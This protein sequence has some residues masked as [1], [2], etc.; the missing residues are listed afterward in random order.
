MDVMTKDLSREQLT[1]LIADL[2]QN[3]GS[4]AAA[5]AK[6]KISPTYI[7]ELLRG[8]RTPGP[9]ILKFFGVERV[10]TNKKK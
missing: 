5:A 10:I 1:Q 2:V 7:G 6:L 3:E 4:Q 9:S 8:T